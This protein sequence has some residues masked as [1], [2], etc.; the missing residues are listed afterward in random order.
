M[1][2]ITLGTLIRAFFVDY[3]A[4][5]KG[6]RPTSIRSYRDTVRLLLSFVSADAQRPISQLRMEH[7]TF[8]RVLGF[9][10]HL[11]TTRHNHVATRN[12]R[13]AGLRTLFE[14][15]GRRIPEMLHV[16]ERVAAIPTKRTPC[17]ETR[18]LDREEIATLFARLPREGRYA[19]RDHALLLMLYNT[20]ARV[21]EIADLRIE[22]VSL[23]SPL[24][25]RLHG[26]GDKW[27]TCPLWEATARAVRRLLDERPVTDPQAPLFTSATGRPLTRV[28]IYKRVR[29]HAA[30]LESSAKWST[31]RI[32]PHVFRHTTAVHLLEA[33]VE[34][35]VIRGWLGHVSLETTNRYADITLRMKEAA[36]KL[37]EPPTPRQESHP[38]HW[39][40]DAALLRWLSSL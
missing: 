40:D 23:V 39:R 4:G 27:R 15:V 13:L 18:F 33:G 28:G 25:V 7:L 2:T 35:N 8:E 29:Q 20:G 9:L 19:Q 1:T 34:V 38:S 37:C 31:H 16:C 21:Q 5:Q 32:T 36:M 30:C 10:Q 11:E 6:L 26:K 24:H 14:Y 3:L 22:H 17:P 12:Q